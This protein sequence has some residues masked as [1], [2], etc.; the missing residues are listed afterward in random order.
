MHTGIGFR[1][2]AVVGLALTLWAGVS[3]PAAPARADEKIRIL[4][5]TWS[6]YAPVFVAQDLGYFKKLGIDVDIKFEDERA[7]VMAAMDRKD[8]EM[9]MR[10]VGEYQG[11]PRD[12]K[13]PGVIIGTIDESLGGDGVIAP[14]DITSVEQLK[15][16]T[17]ASEPNIPGRLLLQ[18]ELKKKGMTLA[19]LDVKQIAT[20]DTVAVFADPSISAVVSYQPNL[21]QA[22][23][24]IK[25]R[26][27]HVLISSAQYP[28]IIVD[29]IIVRQ[30]DLKA[31]PEKYK[32]FMIGIFKAI[33]Y[34]KSN[35]QDFVKLA[36]PHFNLTP[37]EFAASIDGSLD[38]TDY[39]QTAGYFGKPGAPGSLYKVFDEVMQLNLENGAADH[40]L[41]S[42]DQIDNSVVSGITEADLK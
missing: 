15:G 6:G 22:L 14:G 13:T 29:V 32:K 26:N 1:R 42:A 21:S 20:A 18:M 28:G 9:D 7:N 37:A 36:A 3:L 27:P 4:C 23:D 31:N 8:I 35:K 33:D 11:K 39:K 40:K 30:D 19:D 2:L 38:Y 10:T 12:D 34:F 41:K 17:V 16:K 24:K 25:Q 5:P